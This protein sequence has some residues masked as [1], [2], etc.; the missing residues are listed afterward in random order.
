MSAVFA[1]GASGSVAALNAMRAPSGDHSN[2]LTLYI[3]LAGVRSV[4][5]C[6]APN[7]AATS[8]V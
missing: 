8:I 7:A 1:E 3:A 6:G 4:P 5:A 2:P